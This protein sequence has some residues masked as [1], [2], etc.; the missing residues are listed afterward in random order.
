MT[1]KLRVSRSRTNICMEA[2]ECRSKHQY[3]PG[4]HHKKGFFNNKLGFCFGIHRVWMCLTYLLAIKHGNGKSRVSGCFHATILHTAYT[5]DFPLLR[6]GVQVLASEILKTSDFYLPKI[7]TICV[8][9]SF[10]WNTIHVS[11]NN[12]LVF[13][14]LFEGPFFCL[15]VLSKQIVVAR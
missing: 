10:S 8:Q 2:T 12:F 11:F 9:I 14:S 3:L 6:T 1:F 15:K 13:Y 5:V 4:H 7:S